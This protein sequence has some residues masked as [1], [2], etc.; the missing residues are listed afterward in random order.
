MCGSLCK[1]PQPCWHLGHVTPA[2]G[3]ST[4]VPPQLHVCTNM[5]QLGSSAKW[6]HSPF[7]RQSCLPPSLLPEMPTPGE[8]HPAL[9]TPAACD[10]LKLAEPRRLQA[11]IPWTAA[12]SSPPFEKPAWHQSLIG[13]AWQKL[14]PRAEIYFQNKF[15]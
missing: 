9:W 7:L 1:L 6:C 3:P 4:L 8:V 13:S 12:S 2:L 10:R 14:I 11:P 5:G 15:P